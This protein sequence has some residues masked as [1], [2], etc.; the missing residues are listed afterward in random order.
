[1]EK[2]SFGCTL[3][4]DGPSLP[5]SFRVRRRFYGKSRSAC[6]ESPLV[7]GEWTRSRV[8]FTSGRMSRS[9]TRKPRDCNRIYQDLFNAKPE[10]IYTKAER[11]RLDGPSIACRCPEWLVCSWQKGEDLF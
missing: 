1:M 11:S 4:Q 7:F 2:P 10:A 5:I 3:R 8:Q 6:G 9:R